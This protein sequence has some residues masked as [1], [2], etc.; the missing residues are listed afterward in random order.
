MSVLVGGSPTNDFKVQRGLRQG[1]SLSY[2]LFLIAAEGLSALVARAVEIGAFKGYSI[3]DDL[4]FP[5]MQFADD[6]ILMAKATWGKFME[7]QDYL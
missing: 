1:D 2:F 7:H 4:R 5:I 6:T 3:N